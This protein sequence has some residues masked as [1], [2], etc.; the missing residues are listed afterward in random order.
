MHPVCEESKMLGFENNR[1]TRC[2]ALCVFALAGIQELQATEKIE[3]AA[4]EYPPIYQNGAD[5]GLS[6]DIAV[7]AFKAVDVN[8]ELRFFPV[9]RMILSVSTGQSICAIGGTV[10]FE[11]AQ[12]MESVRIGSV[13]QYVVQ[14]F[15]FDRRKYPEGVAYANLGQLR[16]FKIGA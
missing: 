14:T 3:L 15:V 1:I 11:E 4:F 9:A 7:A 13:I 6:G 2:A 5:K 10:L 12:V 16:N 8:A